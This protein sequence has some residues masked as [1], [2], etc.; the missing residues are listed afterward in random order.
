[1]NGVWKEHTAVSLITSLGAPQAWAK[2]IFSHL[3]DN[4]R[5]RLQSQ[6]RLN[7][8]AQL[9]DN[10]RVQHT[11]HLFLE[12]LLLSIEEGKENQDWC[13]ASHAIWLIHNR[14]DT[15]AQRLGGHFLGLTNQWHTIAESRKQVLQAV[16]FGWIFIEILVETEGNGRRGGDK[17]W[18]KQGEKVHGLF[19][20]HL[21]VQSRQ[22]TMPKEEACVCC[23]CNALVQLMHGI[24]APLAAQI[25]FNL[26]WCKDLVDRGKAHNV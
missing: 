2:V 12:G 18:R 3:L 10:V 24:Q 7:I 21:Q 4:V 14:G 17:Y 19:Q 23:A 26:P 1:M 5:Q 25:L 20:T 22:L 13:A 9:L 15:H 6:V 8:L 16:R 11:K